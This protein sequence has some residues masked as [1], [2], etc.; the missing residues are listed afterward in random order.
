MRRYLEM[1]KLVLLLVLLLFS[2]VFSQELD[3]DNWGSEIQENKWPNIEDILVRMTRKPG[4]RQSLCHRGR[5][6]S[7][8]TQSAGKR[9]KFQTFVGLM[10][11]RSSHYKGIISA[12]GTC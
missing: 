2:S 7:V 10:G 9:H 5:K 6:G 12:A 8:K 4:Q 3:G 1:V 11:K